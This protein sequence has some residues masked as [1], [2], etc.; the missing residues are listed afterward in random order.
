MRATVAVRRRLTSER[1][2]STGG[3][4]LADAAN[5]FTGVDEREAMQRSRRKVLVGVGTVFAS[6]AV[7][8][9]SG[10][11]EG[12]SGGE[13]TT[14]SEETTT[15]QTATK[16]AQETTTTDDRPAGV[17]GDWFEGVS[18]Y[19][20]LHD[21]RGQSEVR[22]RVGAEG[23][24][25]DFAFAP[26][27]VQIDPGATVVWEWTGNGGG[28]NVVATDGTFDSGS[29]VAEAG[30]NYRYTFDEAGVHRYYCAPHR[31]LGMKGGVV[32]GEL[33]DDA[34]VTTAE[35]PAGETPRE[36]TTQETTQETTAQET[37]TRSG[38]YGGWLDDVG[39]YDGT[40]TDRTDASTV[41]VKVGAEGN[42]GNIAFEPPA[43]QVS[44]GTT[45]RWKWTGKGGAHNVYASDG[46]F[47]S[48]DPTSAS[49]VH[50]T[51]TFEE[52]GLYEYYC[53]PHKSLGMKG[54]VEVLE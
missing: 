19:D 24:D 22:V 37:T 1:T 11:T 39:N 29:P 50:L 32:V 40:P 20:G 48:G 33:P 44:T 12:G 51:Y 36:T 27:A 25:G 35:E 18:N 17:F 54:L 41:T 3:D 16:A 2:S 43:L 7:A 45:V 14:R 8:G 46:A 10:G 9:C 47:K 26:A 4:V 49:G 21:R 28:H 23:N 53:A 52:P 15:G 34:T 6:G 38:R 13:T 30:V 5:D 42:G 31:A